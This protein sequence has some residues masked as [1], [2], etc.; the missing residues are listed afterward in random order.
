M[1]FPL[2]EAHLKAGVIHLQS[3]SLPPFYFL[4]CTCFFYMLDS[5]KFTHAASD[6]DIE[7]LH[8]L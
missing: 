6:H 1:E 4:V 2:N 5:N 3:P 7:W 8:N